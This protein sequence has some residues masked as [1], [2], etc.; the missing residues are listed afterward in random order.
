MISIGNE[1][2]GDSTTKQLALDVS[3]SLNS[4]LRRC[5]A[6]STQ[7]AQTNHDGNVA[8]SDMTAERRK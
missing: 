2:K 8:S 6:P 7:F 1:Q 3:I 4:S 5:D